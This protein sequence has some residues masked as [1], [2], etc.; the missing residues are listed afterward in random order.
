LP[1][2]NQ[3]EDESSYEEE[4][5][6]NRSNAALTRQIKKKKRANNL[7]GW[8]SGRLDFFVRP[9][10][11]AR[12]V[13]GVGVVNHILAA[14]EEYLP[15]VILSG[16]YHNNLRDFHVL[17]ANKRQTVFGGLC[18]LANGITCPLL[19]IVSV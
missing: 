7:V 4:G 15:D 14:P 19:L 10:G 16:A 1:E 9:C 5:T 6:S 8:L 13:A 2:D 11:R 18:R 12:G 3:D 17:V